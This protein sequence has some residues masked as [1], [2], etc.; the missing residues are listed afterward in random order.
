MRKCKVCKTSRQ[1]NL[2]GR[3][4]FDETGTRWAFKDVCGHC[5]PTRRRTYR[6]R[7][8]PI[9]HQFGERKLK[10]YDDE[11]YTPIP[12]H[13]TTRKCREC[14]NLIDLCRYYYCLICQPE[15]SRNSDAQDDFIYQPHFSV[16]EVTYVSG[17]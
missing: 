17:I 2:D 6:T 8:A 7:F 9:K 3:I 10:L 1:Y 4:A 16:S 14:N 12:T 15:T 11:D 5:L 13:H